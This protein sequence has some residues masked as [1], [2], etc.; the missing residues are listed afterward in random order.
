MH[1]DTG[2]KTQESVKRIEESQNFFIDIAPVECFEQIESQY[3]AIY[4]A[5]KLKEEIEMVY[6]GMEK[7][8]NFKY[9]KKVKEQ[10]SSIP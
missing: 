7:L 9:G 1:K 3:N 6:I 8:N 10:K 4:E 2:I 5:I